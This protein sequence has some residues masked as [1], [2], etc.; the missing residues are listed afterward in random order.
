MD[1]VVSHVEFRVAV[2]E[3]GIGRLP[4]VEPVVDGV[5]FRELVA[6]DLH[7]GLADPGVRWPAQHFLGE[8]VLGA[9]GRTG[10]LGC[11]C[12]DFGCGPLTAEVTVTDAKVTWSEFRGT[13]DDGDLGAVRFVFARRQY[14]SALRATAL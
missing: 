5:P 1:E 10:I 4:T 3:L 9:G 14:E 13:P 7:A 6:S 2:E 11:T 8:P 12:G